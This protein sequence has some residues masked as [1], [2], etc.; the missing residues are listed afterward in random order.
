MCISSK[1]GTLQTIPLTSLEQDVLMVDHVY[2]VFEHGNLQ[3]QILSN[4]FQ[5][6]HAEHVMAG[7]LCLCM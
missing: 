3:L 1:L 4:S 6:G 5:V 7:S 2:E